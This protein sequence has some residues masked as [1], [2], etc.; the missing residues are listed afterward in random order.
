[1]TTTHP[2][3]P[4]ATTR[5]R[6]VFLRW[7]AT[8]VGFPL[9][10]LTAMLVVGPVDGLAAATL[11]GAL[12]GA[13][14]GAVQAWGRRLGRR[15]ALAWT[16]ATTL[17]L[18]VGLAAGASVVGFDTDLGHL[19]VQGLVTGGLVGLLQGVLLVRSGFALGLAW[20]AYVAAAWAVGW[21][22]TTLVGVRVED[23]FTVFGSAGAITVTALTSVL[24]LVIT[25]PG[26]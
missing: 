8:F 5:S 3:V 24:S 4:L 6:T 17:G 11:G 10:G 22:V 13:V 7:M 1:M 19:V 2:D 14:L 25:R 23:Q 21:A 26:R 20:P 16:G 15:D 18:A 9:G 12:T